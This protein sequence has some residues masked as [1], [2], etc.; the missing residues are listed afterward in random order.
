MT[1]W[2]LSRNDMIGCQ[3]PLHFPH[4]HSQ[5]NR[6]PS[7]VDTITSFL[8]KVSK[9]LA[10]HAVG[11]SPHT[12]T[13]AQYVSM[14]RQHCFACL[15][16]ILEAKQDICNAPPCTNTC[17]LPCAFYDDLPLFLRPCPWDC[18]VNSIHH[19]SRVIV[20]TPLASMMAMERTGFLACAIPP[21]SSSC[22]KE[23]VVLSHNTSIVS[24]VVPHTLN[25][26]ITGPHTTSIAAS[27]FSLPLDFSG[28][29]WACRGW[30]EDSALMGRARLLD[31]L[32][33]RSAA[34]SSFAF[35]IASGILPDSIHS[36]ISTSGVSAGIP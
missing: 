23:Y 16:C 35:I 24:L 31:F 29:F 11:M 18:L 32:A 30:C 20:G 15:W 13:L 19:L 22:R 6:I 34:A 4:T 25:V 27:G 2:C 9:S 33:N 8:H 36:M 17:S 14:L 1:S 10:M 28:V 3:C 21:T 12:Y 26:P 7:V 5:R